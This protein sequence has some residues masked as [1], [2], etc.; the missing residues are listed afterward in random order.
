MH[1][2]FQALR[3]DLPM[4][5][6][7]RVAAVPPWPDDT[8]ADIT[9]VYALW[10]AARARYDASGP[11]RFGVRSIADAFYAPVA[12]RFRSYGV[13]V[14]DMCA[15]WCETLLG[16]AAFRAWEAAAVAEPRTMAVDALYA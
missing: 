13:P 16:D 2:G 10:E 8:A 9:R 14:S 6:R 5:L 12:T 4:N 15:A 3:C 7:R 11:W 1:S